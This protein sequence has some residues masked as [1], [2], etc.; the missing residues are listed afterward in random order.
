MRIPALLVSLCA[1]SGSLGA[2]TVGLVKMPY[3]GARNVPEISGVPDYLEAGGLADRLREMGVRLVPTEEI[4]LT[5]H[6]ERAYG[7]W[8]R[9]GLAN[10]NLSRVVATN[11]SQG[12]VHVGLLANCTSLL[13]VLGG[14]QQL[15]TDPTRIGL[16]F[17]DAHGD[18]NVPETTLSGMLG[19]MPVA[20]AAGLALHNL[21]KESGL[22]VAIPTDNVVLGAVRDLDPLERELVDRHRLARFSVDD[23]RT[24]GVRLHEIM[25]DLSARTDMIYVHVDMD[26]LDPREVAGHPLTVP[27]GPTSSELAAAIR[28]MFTYPKAVAFGVASTPAGER[29]PDGLSLRAAYRLIEGALLGVRD[30]GQ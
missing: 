4:R 25:R 15:V 26:V 27:D 13:G 14:M 2:Q 17:I 23:I 20:V 21:R 8:H 16:V 22:P 11:L 3:T 19:G 30:R 29:D 28:V 9:M 12:Y 10:G 6:Q 18:F 5:P 7:A 1:M 24:A